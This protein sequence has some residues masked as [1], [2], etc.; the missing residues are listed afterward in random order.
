MHRSTAPVLDRRPSWKR[1]PKTK[2]RRPT[3]SAGVPRR[4][5]SLTKGGQNRRG[6]VPEST[7][8]HHLEVLFRWSS[9]CVAGSVAKRPF[10]RSPSSA[11]DAVH[12]LSRAPNEKSHRCQRFHGKN[13]T[14]NGREDDVPRPSER[15][16]L[17]GGDDVAASFGEAQSDGLL[18]FR[19]SHRRR[20]SGAKWSSGLR[21]DDG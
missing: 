4:K 20:R 13:T 16:P 18:S 14:S 17:R 1:S 10:L 19:H 11:L 5:T 8:S 21:T 7:L 9:P 2:T 12:T 15:E 6:R 3:T